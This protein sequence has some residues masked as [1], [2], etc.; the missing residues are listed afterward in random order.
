[1]FAAGPLLVT[2]LVAAASTG[3][4]VLTLSLIGVAGTLLV[5][6]AAPSRR[7]RAEPREAHRLGPLRS[8][9]LPPLLGALFFVGGGP[10]SSAVAAGGCAGSHRGGVGPSCPR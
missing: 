4:A 5:V 9:G 6:T 1:M 10:G 3:A 2:L 8:P 7:W